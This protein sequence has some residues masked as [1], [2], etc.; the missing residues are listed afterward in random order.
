MAGTELQQEQQGIIGWISKKT[1][2][3]L[4]LT[5]CSQTL[6]TAKLNDEIKGTAENIKGQLSSIMHWPRGYYVYLIGLWEQ[7]LAFRQRLQNRSEEDQLCSCS[8]WVCG[9]EIVWQRFFSGLK[10]HRLK[11]FIII[12]IKCHF[13]LG[14][15][16]HTK[17]KGPPKGKWTTK[18]VSFL[19]PG[20]LKPFNTNT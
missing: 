7:Q 20:F 8:K 1:S 10:M 4:P 16:K 2:P 15:N 12:V 19:T 9:L 17:H 6:K 14:E 3:H 13:L 5:V 18:N 11:I